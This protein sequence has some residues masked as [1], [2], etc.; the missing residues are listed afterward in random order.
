MALEKASFRDRTPGLL[1]LITR[2]LYVAKREMHEKHW[3]GIEKEIVPRL[4][5]QYGQLSFGFGLFATKKQLEPVAKAGHSD[6]HRYQAM[7]APMLS[8]QRRFLVVPTRDL[9][10]EFVFLCSKMNQNVR[11][12][13]YCTVN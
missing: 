10:F 4:H 8:Q 7:V 1:G 2:M 6:H 3:K 11:D 12:C 9:D 13:V 5:P